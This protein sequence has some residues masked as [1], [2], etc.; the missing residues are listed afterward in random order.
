MF[1]GGLDEVGLAATR[2]SPAVEQTP[3]VAVGWVRTKLSKSS[4]T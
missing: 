4:L 3:V 2:V 1:D